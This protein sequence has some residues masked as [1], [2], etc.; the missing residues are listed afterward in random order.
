MRTVSTQTLY[1]M[2]ITWVLF[3]ILIV[4][5]IYMRTVQGGGLQDLEPWFYPMMTLHGVGMAGVW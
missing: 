4:L 5:G 1:W 3:P 2:A